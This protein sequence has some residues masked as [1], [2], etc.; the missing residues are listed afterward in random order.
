MA[1]AHAK[2]LSG[3][4]HPP[5]PSPIIPKAHFPWLPSAEMCAANILNH[6]LQSAIHGEVSTATH[7][8]QI[9]SYL[10]WK[11]LKWVLKESGKN[12]GRGL[13]GTAAP[14]IITHNFLLMIS[15]GT[16]GA[17]HSHSCIHL[18]MFLHVLHINNV[19]DSRTKDQKIN[20]LPADLLYL[21]TLYDVYGQEGG[22]YQKP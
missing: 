11:A 14:Y 18:K 19:M 2:E 3:T 12:T 6:R 16:E 20:C 9:I 5:S 1:S 4:L 13:K 8:C 7:S 15:Q 21:G 17:C 10:Y 22:D